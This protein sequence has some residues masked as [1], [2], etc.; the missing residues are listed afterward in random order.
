MQ[1]LFWS[2]EPKDLWHL[3]FCSKRLHEI[4][5]NPSSKAIWAEARKRSPLSRAGRSMPPPPAGTSELQWA[6]LA[7]DTACYVRIKVPINSYLL[8]RTTDVELCPF[9]R[10]FTQMDISSP[11]L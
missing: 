7:F 4:I 9:R 2:T 10:L 6:R 3:S 11:L 5:S 8:L 1:I